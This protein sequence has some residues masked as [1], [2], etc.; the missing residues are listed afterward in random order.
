MN[1]VTAGVLPI[2][3]WNDIN[4][5]YDYT[6]AES[7]ETPVLIDGTGNGTTATLRFDG[8][9]SW[10]NDVTPTNI[11]TGNAQLMNGIIKVSTGKKVGAFIFNNLPEGQ[12]DL[13][14]Y[15]DMNG[16]NT[17]LKVSD[18]NFLTSYYV[19]EQH[20]FRDTNTF[21]QGTNTD[22][23][24]TNDVCNYVK[25]S[26]LGT[27]GIGQVGAVVEW[28]RN[29]D[30]IGIPALQLVNVGAP[31]ANT[32]GLSVTAPPPDRRV[33]VGDSNVVMSVA[34][35]GPVQGI[36]WF[37]T[38]GGVSTPI[39]GATNLAYAGV[40]TNGL[41]FSYTLPPIT[42]GDDG[43][44]YYAVVSN[45][46]N[47]AQSAPG[48]ITVGQL[49]AVPGVLEKLW[50]GATRATVEDGS[51]D[52]VTPDI[53]LSLS[54]F[55]SPEEQGDNFGER[56]SCLFI[57]PVTTNYTFFIT[58]DDDS[59]L[60]LSTDSTPVS[61]RLIAQEV[62]WSNPLSWVSN[63]GGT[64]AHE[65]TQKRSDQWV[66]DPANPPA[67]PP[68]ANGIALDSTK[69]YY[70]EA[71]HH[72]GGGGD[73][74]D[75]TFKIV[76][77]PDPQNGDATRINAFT[78]AP[79]PLALDGAYIVITNQPQSTTVTQS[80]TTT[81]TVAA[82]SAYVGENLLPG[83][84]LALQW[85]SAPSGSANFVNI[86]GANNASYT[87]PVL[88]LSDN[89]TQY[90][91]AMIG[92]TASTNSSIATLNVVA[93]TVPPRPAAIAKAFSSGLQLILTFNEL[94][95]K[96]SAET[97]ANYV[98]NG[99]IVATNASLDASGTTVSLLFA[100][101]FPPV[102]TNVLAISGVKDLAG[103]PVVANTTIS[104]SY[105][106]VTY[107]AD[108]LFD[109][110]IGYYRFED[111]TSSSVAHNSGSTG[112]DGAYYLSDELTPGAGGVVTNAAGDPGPQPPAFVGF[113]A[114]NHSA[115]FTGSAANGGAEEWV[116]TK[117][118][119]LQALPAFSLEYWCKPIRTNAAYA[120]S[121][122][123][124]NRIGLVGQND[125]IEYGFIDPATIQIWTPNGG[126]LNTTY[127][128]PDNEWHHIATIADGTSLKTYYDGKLV[129]TGGS[130]VPPAGGY[131]TSGF[132]VHI[133]GGG[134][135]DGTGNYF[136]GNI[137]EVAI[138]NKAIP[139]ARI[140]EHY[141]A[142]KDGGVITITGVI[143]PP[144]SAG[145]PKITFSRSGGNL[146]IS[147]APTGG[148]LQSASVL[149][150]TSTSWTDL[151]PNNPTNIV[152]GAG[153]S[154]YRVKQ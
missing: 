125:A 82:Y 38:V 62:D 4:D 126:S 50:Y 81:F 79:S 11:T 83:P 108:I 27:Y 144:L 149:S 65:V 66:P 22:P 115:R 1:G 103:N 49:V 132:N 95:D 36:Q 88:K 45:N 123:W 89:G 12:Y 10:Y 93:D 80:L 143:T 109:G 130:T 90:R 137:D 150:A 16:D 138:F 70:M 153:N 77:E 56:L 14:V 67:S 34:A 107:Q 112:G 31:A 17:G 119:F 131:G 37:K 145:G 68:F 75:V 102:V 98:V 87:T 23:S 51:H 47:T 96:V 133:G 152:I 121:T 122:D 104:F 18:N 63:D 124:G 73:K 6:P 136:I 19:V 58:S 72:E 84:T 117:N 86:S 74:V 15:C 7:G 55:G 85:Q 25:L 71:V 44:K 127:T 100:S 154:F 76:G 21:I 139:A 134:V 24:N 64:A 29:S 91:V 52:T 20:Q 94:M 57:P 114:N 69:T 3:I 13:Y 48:T 78:L 33:L 142:G 30:G 92:G 141:S 2:N 99:S 147:W 32:T 46:V 140:A 40:R 128:F 111:A 39:S 61:K 101:A 54:V 28:L 60:F 118:Q 135:F 116:D 105:T 5:A 53:Q 8:N 120:N 42:A 110:P 41:I 151:G 106:L 59:D 113:E 97:A 43:S 146:N 129:G 26:N 148:V 35:L 9:D